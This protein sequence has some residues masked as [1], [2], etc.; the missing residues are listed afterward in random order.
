MD[1]ELRTGNAENFN[2]YRYIT[3][4][5]NEL[6]AYFTKMYNKIPVDYSS[7]LNITEEFTA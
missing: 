4:D 1:I 7:W 5:K 6:L 2:H 3:K